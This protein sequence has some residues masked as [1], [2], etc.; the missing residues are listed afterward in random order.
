M[1]QFLQEKEKLTYLGSA[2]QEYVFSKSSI[3]YFRGIAY[4]DVFDR[5]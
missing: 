4:T 3:L 1:P 5:N 2:D